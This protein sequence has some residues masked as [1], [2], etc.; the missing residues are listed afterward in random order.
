[1]KKII[2]E[3]SFSFLLTL[4][5]FCGSTVLADDLCMVIVSN[6]SGAK[7]YDSPFYEE[8]KE[9][10]VLP[11]GFLFTVYNTSANKDGVTYLR[12]NDFWV[13]SDDVE[14]YREPVLPSDLRI[15]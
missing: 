8:H 11:Y 4:I 7:K 5:L 14:V 1:M 6:P 13:S 15:R 3:I 2:K 9:Y 10:E 12:S